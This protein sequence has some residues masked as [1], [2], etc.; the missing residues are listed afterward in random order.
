ME[1]AMNPGSASTHLAHLALRL[2]LSLAALGPVAGAGL[3]VCL[4]AALALA[5]VIPERALQG[6]RNAVALSQAM[7]PQ[8]RPAAT[9]PAQPG[10]NENL[11]LFYDTLG[12][13]RY[14]EQQV[15]TLFALAA[16]TGLVLSQGEYKSA[17]DQNGRFHTYQVNLPVKGS[18]GAIWQFGMLALRAIPFASLDE[19]SFRRDAIG[20][21]VVEARVRLT[22][23]LADQAPGAL[24]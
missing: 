10:P 3:V 8:A 15:R 14:A 5:W 1:R 4:A 22:L 13:R 21:P 6:R 11:A 9:A 2:R 23:Y 20:E 24:R 12:E 7:M 16:K 18:Y 19:I 17:Y